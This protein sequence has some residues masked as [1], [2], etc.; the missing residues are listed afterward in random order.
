MFKMQLTNKNIMETQNRSRVSGS[1]ISIET[2]RLKFKCIWGRIRERM[3]QAE[4][5]QYKIL[6][7]SKKGSLVFSLSIFLKNHI[8][9]NKIYLILEGINQRKF[10]FLS[11]HIYVHFI[12]DDK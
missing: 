7:S 1:D 9:E 2:Y 5:T 8:S 12:I 11:M 3:P 4:R 10:T 6:E